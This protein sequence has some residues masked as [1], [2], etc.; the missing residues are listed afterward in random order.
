MPRDCGSD[1]ASEAAQALD[2]NKLGNASSI[3]FECVRFDQQFPLKVK[4]LEKTDTG[5][6]LEVRYQPINVMGTVSSMRVEQINF[7]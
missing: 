7:K 3:L 4:A 5:T 6:D 2:E 1:D